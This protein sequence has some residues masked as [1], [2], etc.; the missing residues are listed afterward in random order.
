MVSLNSTQ[1]RVTQCAW[2]VDS[3]VTSHGAAGSGEASV[4]KFCCM[5]REWQFLGWK[6]GKGGHQVKCNKAKNYCPRVRLISSC[7]PQTLKN[8]ENFFREGPLKTLKQILRE[9][10]MSRDV[11]QWPLTP[12]AGHKVLARFQEF[13]T[14]ASG[15]C[16]SLHFMAELL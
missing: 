3:L 7:K 5:P 2:C 4:S 11:T 10:L 8:T 6:C 14:A 9:P 15:Y 13:K 16:I 12:C 1:T